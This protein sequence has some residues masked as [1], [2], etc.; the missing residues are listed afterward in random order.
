MYSLPPPIPPE[1][2]LAN[3]LKNKGELLASKNQAKNQGSQDTY[4]PSAITKM[5]KQ[6]SSRPSN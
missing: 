6:I 4:I 2:T 5:E 3:R 1:S